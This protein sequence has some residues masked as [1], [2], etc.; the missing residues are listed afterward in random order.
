MPFISSIP[1][2]VSA[3]RDT[4]QPG[5]AGLYEGQGDKGGKRPES[6]Q[7]AVAGGGWQR[8]CRYHE[9][10]FKVV[11]SYIDIN[12]TDAN[13]ILREDLEWTQRKCKTRLGFISGWCS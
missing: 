3:L 12:I 6:D 13:R 11:M 1:P 10:P 5:A 2:G 4:G 7:A 9:V 8:V